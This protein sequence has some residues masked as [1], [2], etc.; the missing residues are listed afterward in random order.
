MSSLRFLTALAAA[1]LGKTAIR[2]LGRT[3][4]HT[5]GRIARRI[6]PD[7]LKK[8][9]LPRHIVCITGTNGKTTAA[10]FISD[11]LTSAGIDHVQNTYGSNLQ[12]GVIAA[13]ISKANW[14]GRSKV[15]WGIFEVDEIASK[16]I[17]P[18]LKP[19]IL[20][21]TNLFRDSYRRNAHADYI[22]S[23]L[24]E[25]IPKDALLILNADDLISARIAP[26][27]RRRYFSVPPLPGEPEERTA[28]INDTKL[29]PECGVP[30]DYS[31]QRYHH[32]GRAICPSCGLKNPQADYLTDDVRPTDVCL[33]E[34]VNGQ[35]ATRMKRLGDRITD[36]YNQLTAYAVLREMGLPVETIK[37]AFETIRVPETRLKER[38][39]GHKRVIMMMGKDQNPVANT[40]TLAVIGQMKDAGRIAVL[41][42]NQVVDTD[43]HTENI[44]WIYDCNV[45]YLNQPFIRYVG[46]G[47]P[48]WL[49]FAQRFCLAGIPEE[50]IL[51]AD[52]EVTLADNLDVSEVDTVVLVFGTKKK[53][54]VAAVFDS[55][56]RRLEA[57]VQGQRD[58]EP[59]P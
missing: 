43:F 27:S 9:P 23:L 52:D 36:L 56:A 24:N 30:L 49:D 47:S 28:H 32:I 45:E 1:R 38:R 20:A 34:R 17:F 5:P 15:D 58:A 22:A 26:A 2:L 35:L 41:F 6:D 33:Q 31:F 57:S 55:L 25:S 50:K 18:I 42:V 46:C 51:G 16:T 59:A 7:F 53:D 29:C 19:E 37:S 21:V 39:F 3:G 4:S 11:T 40:R 13:L 44:A 54:I 48:R 8:L 12:E 10:N 14:K